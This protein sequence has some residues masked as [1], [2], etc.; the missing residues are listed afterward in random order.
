MDISTTPWVW[1]IT[2]A[3]GLIGYIF[4]WLTIFFGLAIRNPLLKKY[5]EP[6]Y[7]FD[8]HCF[9]AASAVFWALVHGTSLLFDNMIGFGVADVA[10]PFF[11]KTTVVDTNYL[12]LGILAFYLMLIMAITSYLRRHL[13]FWVW[14]VLH[15]LSPLAFVFVILH[16]YFIGTDMKNFY[17]GGAFLASAFVLLG[18]YLLSLVSAILK[19]LQMNNNQS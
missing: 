17:I 15:F 10:V 4:L 5:I 14:R 8:W 6:F 12:A 7:S 2:R 3:A 13:N 1:Y 16:G 11:S 19:K 18:I 9:M